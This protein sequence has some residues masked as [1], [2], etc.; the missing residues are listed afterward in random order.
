MPTLPGSRGSRTL[1]A[2]VSVSWRGS[3]RTRRRLAA[4]RR[5]PPSRSHRLRW[6]EPVTAHHHADRRQVR[7]AARRRSDHLGDIAEVGRTE[8]SRT[9][10]SQELDIG[11]AVIHEAVDLA[12]SNTQRVAGCEL[13]LFAVDRPRA[14]ALEPVDRLLERVMTVRRR[15][16]RAHGH[17]A[18]EDS[19]AAVRVVG[20]DEELHLYGTDVDGFLL[21][22]VH[23]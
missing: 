5:S 19:H 3:W 21:G 15:N 16:L 13:V 10:D 6:R 17:T 2:F 23:S 7:R 12:A 1:G 22:R 11:R 8:D 14:N 20:V 4:P 9:R 18:F